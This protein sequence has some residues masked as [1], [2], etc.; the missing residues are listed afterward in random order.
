MDSMINC[1]SFPPQ[2]ESVQKKLIVSQVKRKNEQEKKFTH[3][4]W[5]L[6]H[7][8]GIV[9]GNS[10][11][12]LTAVEH[13]KRLYNAQ[14]I[15]HT[16]RTMAQHNTQHECLSHSESGFWG[17][18]VSTQTICCVFRVILLFSLRPGT[19]HIQHVL[20]YVFSLLSIKP[21]QPSPSPSAPPSRNTPHLSSSFSHSHST[22]R[23]R[24]WK[25]L[26]TQ[27][28]TEH[29]TNFQHYC[30]NPRWQRKTIFR[31][32]PFHFRRTVV[33]SSPAHDVSNLCDFI[34]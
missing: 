21:S 11:R 25:Y 7:I 19:T 32:I 2:F 5:H 3:R 28:S 33:A 15:N 30:S 27:H 18:S 24:R 13:N 12:R 4:I 31:L 34:P 29:G 22:P 10:S 20:V 6:L 16:A 17:F 23:R 1:F 26:P 9:E 14:F 8:I